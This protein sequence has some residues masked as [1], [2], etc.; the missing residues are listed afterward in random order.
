MMNKNTKQAN[1]TSLTDKPKTTKATTNLSFPPFVAS[2]SSA[3]DAFYAVQ[4]AN[5]NA[6]AAIVI[7]NPDDAEEER[8]A[9]QKQREMK[10]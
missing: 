2:S 6:T 9:K 5:A 7:T 10:M 8:V 3:W 1:A 4:S